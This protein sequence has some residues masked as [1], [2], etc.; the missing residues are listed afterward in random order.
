M[1]I[2][3]DQTT[4]LEPHA[5]TNTIWQHMKNTAQKDKIIKINNIII[6]PPQL[7]HILE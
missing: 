7:Y 2:E 6:V 3:H 4:I 1:K 5:P